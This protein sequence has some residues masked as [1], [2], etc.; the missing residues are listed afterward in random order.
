M[1]LKRIATFGIVGGALAAWLSAAATSGPRPSATTQEFK[2][3]AI[4]SRGAELSAEIDRLHERLRPSATPRQPGRNLFEFSAPPPRALAPAA[5]AKA[6][7]TESIAA[8]ARPSLK[9]SGLAEDPAPDG[10]VVRT[11]IISA[12]GQLFL[13]K[14]GDLVT[15]RYRIAAIS[16]GV[17]ELVDLLDHSTLRLVLK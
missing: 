13:A 4:D 11:A 8:P 2:A 17:V 12:D 15:P 5:G 16:A 6:A 7:L 14:E 1:N 10:A 9:L 3:P